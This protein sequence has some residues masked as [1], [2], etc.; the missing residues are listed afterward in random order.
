VGTGGAG[1]ALTDASPPDATAENADTS[2]PSPDVTAGPTPADAGAPADT[3]T[4]FG[5]QACVRGCNTASAL[6]CPMSATCISR[7]QSDF[8][9]ATAQKPE[10]RALIEALLA[11]GS[12]RPITD[13]QCGADGKEHLR[14]GICDMEGQRA[15][16]CVLGS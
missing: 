15:L 9:E 2:S 5:R 12:L 6:H 10:C 8:D 7:C 16:Q 14:E 1:G 4:S 13:W 3:A 11:C